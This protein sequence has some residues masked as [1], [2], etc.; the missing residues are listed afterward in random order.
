MKN[1][2]SVLIAGALL[3]VAASPAWAT[4]SPNEPIFDTKK[5]FNALLASVVKANVKIIVDNENCKNNP[6]IFGSFSG[7]NGRQSRLVI[8]AKNHGDNVEELQDTVRHETIHLVQFCNGGPLLPGKSPQI[9]SQAVQDG[10]KHTR[11]P[12]QQWIM[13]G[14]ARFLA[15]RLNAKQVTFLVEQQCH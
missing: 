6:G 13:E 11:Y 12:Y 15:K 10:W 1:V 9:F 14:E 2:F 3:F 5:D 8:C 4:P 7:S